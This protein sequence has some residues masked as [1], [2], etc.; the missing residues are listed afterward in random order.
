MTSQI[1]LHEYEE[2]HVVRKPKRNYIEYIW[3]MGVAR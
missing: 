2:F 1:M 3:K